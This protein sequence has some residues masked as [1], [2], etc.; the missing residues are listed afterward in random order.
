[1]VG[2]GPYTRPIHMKDWM[3]GRPC[4]SGR[5]GPGKSCGHCQSKH[6]STKFCSGCAHDKK[7]H[8]N[9]SVSSDSSES[10][11]SGDSDDELGDVM[12]LLVKLNKRESTSKDGK[13][14]TSKDGKKR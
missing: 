4:C 6:G 2:D 14:G 12:D 11:E 7:K 1:M 5:H 13:R 10:N 9:G 3:Q 8:R